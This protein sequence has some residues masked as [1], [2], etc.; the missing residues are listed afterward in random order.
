M[1]NCLL[2]KE[3]GKYWISSKHLKLSE[4]INELKKNCRDRALFVALPTLVLR[5]C[6]IEALWGSYWLIVLAPFRFA[7]LQVFPGLPDYPAVV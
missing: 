4:R 2:D 7:V 1:L 5:S 3:F 6:N